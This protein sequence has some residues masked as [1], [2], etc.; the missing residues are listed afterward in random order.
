LLNKTYS[1]LLKDIFA[2]R[3]ARCGLVPVRSTSNIVVW[4]RALQFQQ[5]AR[6]LKKL[7]RDVKISKEFLAGHKTGEE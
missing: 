4:V 2:Q 5:I 1:I 6:E 7:G 3:C